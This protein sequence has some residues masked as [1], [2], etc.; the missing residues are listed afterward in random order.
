MLAIVFLTYFEISVHPF[1]LTCSKVNSLIP[2]YNY[3]KALLGSDERVVRVFTR[4]PKVF[5]W[6]YADGFY[7]N[8]SM[9]REIGVPESTIVRLVMRQPN[10]MVISKE[11]LAVYV[12]RAVANG[13]DISKLTFC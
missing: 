1:V 6:S 5:E 11:K 8:I 12:E 9:L 10:M 3:L 13:S 4:A 2:L 7:A